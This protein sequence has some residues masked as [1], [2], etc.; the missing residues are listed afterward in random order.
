M[1]IFF[2]RILYYESSAA[3]TPPLKLYYVE[4][5]L[6][7][8]RPKCDFVKFYHTKGCGGQ[9]TCENIYIL[10]IFFI[11][12]THCTLWWYDRT[13]PLMGKQQRYVFQTEITQ[14]FSVREFDRRVCSRL[15]VVYEIWS[16]NLVY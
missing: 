7:S 13:Q 9:K 15:L 4:Y 2:D 6:I 14:R 11:Y 12:E 5:I 1:C 10:V 8:R 16:I 3:K